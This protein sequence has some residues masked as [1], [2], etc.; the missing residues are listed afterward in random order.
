MAINIIVYVIICLTNHL[1]LDIL[2]GL[3]YFK[4]V[5]NWLYIPEAKSF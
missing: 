4:V 1:L 5:N 3:Q 2:G